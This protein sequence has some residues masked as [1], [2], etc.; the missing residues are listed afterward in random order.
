MSSSTQENLPA[1]AN[2]CSLSYSLLLILLPSPGASYLNNHAYPLDWLYWAF[3]TS[4]EGVP[5]MAETNPTRTNEDVG[6][7]AGLTQWVWDMELP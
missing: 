5:I 7:I 4:E 2:V 6:L 3:R 1:A